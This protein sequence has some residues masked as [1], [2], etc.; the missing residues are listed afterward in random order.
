MMK[1]IDYMFPDDQAGRR[2]LENL[3]LLLGLHL[4]DGILDLSQK[5]ADIFSPHTRMKLVDGVIR[6]GVVFSGQQIP[7]I[8]VGNLDVVSVESD[9]MSERESQEVEVTGQTYVCLDMEELKKR[10]D[11]R[12][13]VIDHTGINLPVSMIENQMWNQLIKG[14]SKGAALF[15]YPG[16]PWPFIVPA[17]SEELDGQITDINVKRGPKFEL[18]YDAYTT[19]PVVQISIGTDLTKEEVHQIF[20][21]DYAV[22]FPN[23]ADL[24]RSVYICSPWNG[25]AIRV[26]VNYVST[27]DEDGLLKYLIKEGRRL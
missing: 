16:E 6:P 26:D 19:L 20:P 27:S 5:F 17:T 7:H 3:A 8:P 13:V 4:Q 25:I 12:P 24:F 18:V 10:L 14:L 22:T 21:G 15:E 11:G 1:H 23:L 2:F 9:A